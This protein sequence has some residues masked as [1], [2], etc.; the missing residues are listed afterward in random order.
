M[1]ALERPAGAD[2]HHRRDLRQHGG[3]VD[4]ADAGEGVADRPPPRRFACGAVWVR[5]RPVVGSRA[6]QLVAIERKATAEVAIG[7]GPD[8]EIAI[9][10]V[11][12][13]TS[14]T[15]SIALS[16]ARH[17]PGTRG[18]P[19]CSP[20]AVAG[21]RCCPA[22]PASPPVT[23]CI[24]RLGKT[25]EKPQFGISEVD[26]RGAKVARRRADGARRS[27][28]AGCCASNA[29]ATTPTWS[30]ALERD[31]VVLV[32]A[33]LSGHH[34]TLLRDT[35]RTLLGHHDVYVTDWVDA[36]IVPLDAG[37]SRST[38]TSA[39]CARSSA[40]SAP[41]ACTSISV[42]QPAV[43]VLAAVALMAAARRAGAAQP[44]ADGRPDRRAPQP[45]PGQP[46]SP[47]ASRSLVRDAT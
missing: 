8:L 40:T 34:A 11:P 37:R 5:R 42:C 6:A 31:P 13:F 2:G 32:V 12:C 36:R 9:L 14:F 25:Y 1:T 15:S 33:P 38:T 43:P 4:P 28:S 46:T 18:R 47:P 45:D 24:Y 26:V 41:T 23:S 29:A 17:P 30:P 22:R 20:R 16:W 10:A 3:G 39:I 35:V 21:C 27:R 19:A 7:G 44:D